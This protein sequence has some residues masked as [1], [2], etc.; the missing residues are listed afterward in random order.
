[1][2]L[3]EHCQ[4]D[5]ASPLPPAGWAAR[6]GGRN[7]SPATSLA[8]ALNFASEA[9]PSA[10]RSNSARKPPQLL[11]AK[12]FNLV[13]FRILAVDK[14]N[15]YLNH[16]DAKILPRPLAQPDPKELIAKRRTARDK[17]LETEPDDDEKK[18]GEEVRGRW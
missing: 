17:R 8:R 4:L 11:N 13:E 16:P 10:P 1:M 3:I 14:L 18:E 15:F 6:A 5:R 12:G 2:V 9:F 7:R